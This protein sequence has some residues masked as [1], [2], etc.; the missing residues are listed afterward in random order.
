VFNLAGDM[1][2]ELYQQ[3]EEGYVDWD[4]IT[5][6]R[7]KVVSGLYMFVVEPISGDN[8]IGK[9]VVVR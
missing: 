1:I 8:F 2:I 6:N 9:F 3:G 7:Q 5:R 4:L